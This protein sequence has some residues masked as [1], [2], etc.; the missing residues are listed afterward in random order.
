MKKNGMVLERGEKK[1]NRT[2]KPPLGGGKKMPDS[3]KSFQ[4][5][6]GFQRSQEVNGGCKGDES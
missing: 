1:K 4:E 3:E 2:G 6:T 5:E